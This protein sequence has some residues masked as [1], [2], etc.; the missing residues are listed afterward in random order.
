MVTLIAKQDSSGYQGYEYKKISENLVTRNTVTCQWQRQRAQR[1]RQQAQRQRQRTQR[2][3]QRATSTA[4]RTT[5]TVKLWSKRHK[6]RQ[7][8]ATH[9]CRVGPQ[10]LATSRNSE[11]HPPSC[12]EWVINIIMRQN[13]IN[14]SL[15]ECNPQCVSC[16]RRNTLL[17]GN[18]TM[19]SGREK[20]CTVINFRTT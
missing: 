3:R 8:E 16:M 1:Q 12:S 15:F 5:S 20:R 19:C 13:I 9:F 11:D 18:A 6:P 17:G 2:Q 7:K 10:V 14:M 4:A